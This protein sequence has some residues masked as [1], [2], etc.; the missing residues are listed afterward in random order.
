MFELLKKE[1]KISDLVKLYL[2]SGKEVEGVVIE[3]GDDNVQISTSDGSNIRLFDKLIG[4]G[5]LYQPL[6]TI[7][8][9]MKVHIYSRKELPP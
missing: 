1:I 4:V 9:V 7:K 2:I 6:I 5:N 8:M 3:L